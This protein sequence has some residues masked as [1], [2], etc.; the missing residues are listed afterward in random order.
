[1][2]PVS[3]FSKEFKSYQILKNFINFQAGLIMSFSRILQTSPPPLPGGSGYRWGTIHPQYPVL[4]KGFVVQNTTN[5]TAIVLH[6]NQYFSDCQARS[7]I[8]NLCQR[9]NIRMLATVKQ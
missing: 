4:G 3:V 2:I 5:N 9:K 7:K 1:L 6:G 8:L